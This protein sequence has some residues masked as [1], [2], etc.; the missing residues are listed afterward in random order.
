MTTELS[1]RRA[2]LILGTILATL[3]FLRVLRIGESRIG[4]L[5]TVSLRP[6]LVEAPWWLAT[7]TILAGLLLVAGSLSYGL[8]PTRRRAMTQNPLNALT[9]RQRRDAKRKIR[10]RLPVVPA[11]IPVLRRA[12]EANYAMR[13]TVVPAVGFLLL[14]FGLAMSEDRPVVSTLVAI[15]V[16]VVV[17]LVLREVRAARAF[18]RTTASTG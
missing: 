3:L 15:P 13:W 1:W 8:M 18:L 12:A 2:F 5:E 11:E 10:G 7:A 6:V 16:L 9:S 4:L 14:V 17:A